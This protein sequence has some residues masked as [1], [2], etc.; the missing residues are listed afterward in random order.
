MI[1][2]NGTILAC[3]DTFYL[4][5]SFIYLTYLLNLFIYLTL[6]NNNVLNAREN[7]NELK[8]AYLLAHSVQLYLLETAGPL[9]A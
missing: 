1:T 6:L 2:G 9:A 4:L 7:Y 5:C 8:I 3:A